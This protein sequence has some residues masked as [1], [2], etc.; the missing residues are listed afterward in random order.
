MPGQELFGGQP[1]PPGL[2]IT[3]KGQNY[4]TSST[5]PNDPAHHHSIYLEPL[6]KAHHA[7]TPRVGVRVVMGLGQWVSGGLGN[8]D[9]KERTGRT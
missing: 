6:H 3:A 7:R 4:H 8:Y 1:P 9:Q 2:G 5:T